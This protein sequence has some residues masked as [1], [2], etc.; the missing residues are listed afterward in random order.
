MRLNQS[1][2]PKLKGLRLAKSETA[3]DVDLNDIV[4]Q[5][6]RNYQPEKVI[7]F[8]S[9]AT[10]NRA[11]H[12][13]FDLLVIKKTDI[14]RLHR[15]AEALRNVD[16]NVPLDLLILTRQE[17][18]LLIAKNSLFIKSILSEGVTLYAE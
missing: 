18:Q 2:W 12:G 13:D 6:V 14:P 8:G 5:I 1:P 15:R 7:L 4:Q 11:R 9:S 10:E 17:V 3:N 16:Y